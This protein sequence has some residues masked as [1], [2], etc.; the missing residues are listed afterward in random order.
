MKRY[1]R[2]QNPCHVSFPYLF[3]FYF[4][5]VW[6]FEASQSCNS[7]W[8]TLLL[9]VMTPDYNLCVCVCVWGHVSVMWLIALYYP[10][11][12]CLHNAL[13]YK[14][15]TQVFM[16]SHNKS[17]SAPRCSS[18][19]IF[20]EEASVWHQC[21]QPST[22]LPLW[23]SA[24]D[25]CVFRLGFNMFLCVCGNPLLVCLV[26]TLK[27]GEKIDSLDNSAFFYSKMYKKKKEGGAPE[28][29]NDCG[30]KQ[31]ATEKERKR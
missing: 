15:L 30:L 8:I 24:V 20:S 22:D 25:M 27:K 16:A 21:V 3:W 17:T 28:M 12:I 31:A 1:V 19:I 11:L 9:T 2:K 13:F 4:I 18:E 7:V 6:P 14:E 23:L 26:Q 10:A 5:T 29:T